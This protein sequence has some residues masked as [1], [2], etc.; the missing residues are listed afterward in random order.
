MIDFTE[1]EATEKWCPLSRVL[2]NGSTA[3]VSFNRLQKTSGSEISYPKGSVCIASHCMAWK[4][5]RQVDGEFYGFC[6]A[7]GWSKS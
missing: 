4:Y 3:P 2:E 6:G 5:S 1:R 7:F